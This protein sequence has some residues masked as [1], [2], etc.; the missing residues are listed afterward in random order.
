MAIQRSENCEANKVVVAALTLE[1][2]EELVKG[3]GKF[4]INFRPSIPDNINNWQVFKD[5]SQIVKF[6]NNMQ[7]F[8]DCQINFQDEKDTNIKE[9]DQ[10]MNRIPKNVVEWESTFDRQD[11]YKKR[12]P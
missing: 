6:I 4:E 5:D 2:S 9:E 12:K 7:E 10:P 11:I 1:F 8:S 3:D